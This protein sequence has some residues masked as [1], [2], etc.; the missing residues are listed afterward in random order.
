MPRKGR[1]KSSTGI[2]HVMLR[3]IN[4]QIIFEEKGDK[5][6]LLWTLKK[7]KEICKYELY[8]YCLMDNHVHLLMKECGESISE[9]I[10]RIS[11]SY[12]F[13]YNT[14][15]ERSGHLFQDRFKSENV[16]SS[17]S[18]L[19]VLRYIHQN[20]MKAGLAES[21]FESEWTSFHEY[22]GEAKIVDTWAALELFSTAPD[23][24]KAIHSFIHYM[25]E[26]N[27][28]ECMDYIV[29]KNMP[30]SEVIEKLNEFG[31]TTN[32]ILQQMEKKD[33]D[34]ML[35][36]LKNLNGVTVKQLARITGISKS[37][38]YRC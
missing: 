37:V 17:T 6:R 11:S 15:Y 8:G 32:S 26:D 12:V 29:K 28:D 4:R 10:K 2:Y 38:I 22:V 13:W 7:Y 16:E 9:A 1:K 31:I 36:T 34:A 24:R 21:V 5:S 30:D 18:F 35:A 33:R 19:T 14:K 27:D 3:G 20:P 25:N 23:S